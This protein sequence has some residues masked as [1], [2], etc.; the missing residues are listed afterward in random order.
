MALK[1]KCRCGE[2]L[3][4]PES[5]AGKKGKCPKCGMTFVIPGGPAAGAAAA[6]PAARQPAAAAATAGDSL[7]LDLP[8]LP[9][10][11]PLDDLFD[12]SFTQQPAGGTNLVDHNPFASPQTRSKPKPSRASA[13]S[14]MNK[15]ANGIKLVFWGSVM[16][17][18]AGVMG[19]FAG[20]L[21]TLM[22][23]EFL[24]VAAAASF[25]I[26]VAGGILSIVGRV[27]CLAVPPQVGAKGLI[28]PAVALDG[29]GIL[30]GVLIG[31][32]GMEPAIGMLGAGLAGF[33]TF[34]LFV[35][36][37][38]KVALSLKRRDLADDAKMVLIMIG[39]TF[40]SVFALAFIPCF[41]AL[42]F[43]GMILSLMFKYLNL[44]QHTAEAARC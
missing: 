41:G 26:Q 44:L 43:L 28:V 22:G 15:V 18:F 37:V 38:R 31:T 3:S 34:L 24:L 30:L 35:L 6:Q 8:D 36:F 25:F 33:V 40:L 5:A 20:P 19:A 9:P 16:M 1:L 32:G 14:G 42:F 39:V 12:E 23:P 10:A 11:G 7:G 21:T 29:L 2:R 27:F 4:A 13:R 17:V